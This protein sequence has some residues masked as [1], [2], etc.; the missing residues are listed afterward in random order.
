MTEIPDKQPPDETSD[1][2]EARRAMQR[3][4]RILAIPS[5]LA[6]AFFTGYLLDR[7]LGTGNLFVL[8][9][10]LCGVGAV[11]YSV[12]RLWKNPG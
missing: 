1:A 2:A 9:F 4:G 5:T 8:L 10:G 12:V 6:G 11:G 7:W 3:A